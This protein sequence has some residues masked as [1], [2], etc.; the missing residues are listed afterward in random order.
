MNTTHTLFAGAIPDVYDRILVPLLFA[1]YGAD[2]AARVAALKPASLLEVAAGTGALTREMAS[3]IDTPVCIVATDL[4]QPMLD[5]AM[6]KLGDDDRIVFRQADALAL[7]FEASTFDVVACQF[8]VMFYPDKVQGYREAYRV[9]KPGG[10]F[11]FNAWDKIATSE[12]PL[13]VMKALHQIFPED[14]PRFMEV[15]PHGYWNTDQ[16]RRELAEAGFHSITVDNLDL[17]SEAASA[18][19]AAVAFCQGTPMRG[20]IETRAP[21]DL[22]AVTAKVTEALE[23]RFGRGP[24]ESTMRANVVTA[25]KS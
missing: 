16:I 7:P 18:S 10:H 3:R 24:I 5:V 20:E 17:P 9:L 23:R 15:T 4:N 12:I 14:P 11:L 25:L 2:M 1:P 8:G 21:G 22:N 6:S 19:D 13:E